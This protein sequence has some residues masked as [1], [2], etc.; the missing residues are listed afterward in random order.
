MSNNLGMI[1]WLVVAISFF[2]GG[3]LLFLGDILFDKLTAKKENTSHNTK[4]I[5]MLISSIT[6]HNIP[7]GIVFMGSSLSKKYR[8]ICLLIFL[9]YQLN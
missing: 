5:V 3:L 2:S 7:D 6:L 9:F 1:P 4:R 8:Q